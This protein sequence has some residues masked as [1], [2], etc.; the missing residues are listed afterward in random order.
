MTRRRG[1]DQVIPRPSD[2][3]PGGP[4][5]WSVPAQPVPAGAVASAVIDHAASLDDDAF[6]PSFPDARPSAVLVLLADGPGGAE[7]LLTR[8]TM[9]LSS[10]RG[11]VSCPGGR[12]DPGETYEE[13]ALR[14]AWEEVGIDRSGVELVGRLDPIATVVSRSWI[15]P[16]VGLAA[17]RHRPVVQAAEVD[18]AFWHP[19]HD[20]TRPG[21]FREELWRLERGEWPVYFFE[22]DDETVWGATARILHQVLRLGLV[23]GIR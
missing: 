23:G 15:V 16:V 7:V 1:G 18:R 19:L 22:L 11:E 6:A 13:A 14:E 10:H 9:H 21:T 4:P 3:T 5:P 8:R 12:L 17:E 2:W 20:L